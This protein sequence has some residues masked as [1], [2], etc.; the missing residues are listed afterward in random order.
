M[1]A[2]RKKS[3]RNLPS[4]N[5][6]DWKEVSLLEKFIDGTG[7]ITS[8]KANGLDAK[9]QRAMSNAIKRARAAGL[10]PYTT[11]GISKV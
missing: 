6:I 9:R 4:L 2:F 10:L 1:A 11:R 3:K 8:R 7:R 5:E